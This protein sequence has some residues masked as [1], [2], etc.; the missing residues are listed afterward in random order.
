MI[1]GDIKEIGIREG[2]G[3]GRGNR[4]RAVRE[5]RGRGRTKKEKIGRVEGGKRE[6]RGRRMRYLPLMVSLVLSLIMHKLVSRDTL[7]VASKGIWK[8]TR[9]YWVRIVGT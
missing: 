5:D 2:W 8:A 6:G 3:K 1:R 7:T 9:M 4:G